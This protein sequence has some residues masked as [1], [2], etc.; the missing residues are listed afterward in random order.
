MRGQGHDSN[1]IIIVNTAFTLSTN[2]VKCLADQDTL[3]LCQVYTTRR[4]VPLGVNILNMIHGHLRKVQAAEFVWYTVCFLEGSNPRKRWYFYFF[5][6]RLIEAHH[7]A[8]TFIPS[9]IL[10]TITSIPLFR[11]GKKNHNSDRR[12]ISFL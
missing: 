6:P 9:D 7:P 1:I 3:F 4:F 11:L 5:Y 2:V 12:N 10:Y 8:S